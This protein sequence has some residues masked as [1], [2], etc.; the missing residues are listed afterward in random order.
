MSLALRIVHSTA[1]SQSQSLRDSGRL[2]EAVQCIWK[3]SM[4]AL[5]RPPVYPNIKDTYQ[6][7]CVAFEDYKHVA[8]ICCVS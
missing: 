4:D 5:K 2:N 8:L 3:M 6:V 1:S 7:P